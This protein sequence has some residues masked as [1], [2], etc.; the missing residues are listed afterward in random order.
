MSNLGKL[1]NRG[2]Q[3]VGPLV[4]R[5]SKFAFELLRHYPGRPENRTLAS[6]S[7]ESFKKQKREWQ[8]R[9]LYG[10][11]SERSCFRESEAAHIV[12]DAEIIEK[13][14]AADDHT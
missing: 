4:F 7:I 8:L 6:S 3:V 13:C 12:E 1:Y 5:A 10:L 9:T 14:S 2:L 11:A